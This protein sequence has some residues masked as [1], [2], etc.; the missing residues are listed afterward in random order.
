MRPDKQR[1]AALLFPLLLGAAAMAAHAQDGVIE[2]GRPL[3]DRVLPT[4]E[5]EKTLSL[6]SFRGR[7]LL[8]IE[9]ASW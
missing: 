1:L 6:S 4:V 5:G 8:L 7:K 9:F 3:P 2:V